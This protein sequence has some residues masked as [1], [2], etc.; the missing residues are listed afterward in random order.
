MSDIADLMRR[1]RR[2]GR[3]HPERALLQD[4]PLDASDTAVTL[5]QADLPKFKDGGILVNFDDETDELAITTAP[6]DTTALTVGVS[7]G[8]DG[9]AAAEH[10]TATALLLRPRWSNAEIIDAL[11]YVVDNEFWPHVWLAGE[12]SLTYQG[13]TEYYS[14]AVPDIEEIVYAY[15]L[16][17]GV[18]YQLHAEWLSPELADDANFPDGAVTIRRAVDASKIYLAYRARPTLGT[19]TS[20]L[21]NLAIMGAFAELVMA[22]E[23]A[24]V[25]GD[26][27][28]TQRQVQ[29]GSR[30]RAGAVMWDRFERARI[31]ERI[32][33]QHEEQLARRRFFGAGRG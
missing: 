4:T 33:L 28:A 2:R 14:P 20:K 22:E 10:P 8:Q 23:G 9:T 21:E 31:G 24:H 12:T 18:R 19:L 25:G 30:L 7:R 3:D 1:V 32:R 11:A 29:D 26:T 27:S 17:G 15:Q 16:S 13:A 6:A 5:L